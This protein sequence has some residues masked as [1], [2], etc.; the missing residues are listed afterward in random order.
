MII[1]TNLK[2]QT[3]E[4][5]NKKLSELLSELQEIKSGITNDQL[6]VDIYLSIQK[7]EEIIKLNK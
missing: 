7:L 3:K 1:S 4:L 5:I 6:S 2:A